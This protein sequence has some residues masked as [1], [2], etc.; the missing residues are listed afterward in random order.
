[1]NTCTKEIFREICGAIHIHTVYSDGSVEYGKLIEVAQNVG[2]DFVI[3]TDHM[4][5]KGKEMGHEGIVDNKFLVLVGYEHNDINDKNHYLVLGTDTVIN[6]QRSA[7][8]YVR[9]VKQAGGIGFIAHPFEKRNYFKKYPS[10]PWTAWDVEG[11]TGIELWN[12]MSEWMEGLKSWKNFFHL[13][14]PRRFLKGPPAGLLRLWDTVNQTRFV[15]GFGGVDAHTFD[16]GFGV[17]RYKIFPIKVELKGIRTH[18]YVASDFWDN[19]FNG[20]KSVVL[21]ALGNGRCFFSNYRRGDARKALFYVMYNDGKIVPP[22]LN[23][24]HAR[25]PANLFVQLPGKGEIHL[26]KNG[27]VAAKTYGDQAEFPLYSKGLYRI[28][29]YRGRYAWIYSNPFPLGDYPLY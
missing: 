7:K 15:S 28:E 10:Y 5:L 17:F 25:F 20:A 16:F 6:E 19:D 23:S 9:L 3:V 21:D 18:L 14:F 4:S 8:K 22:G 1:M 11:Y 27:T 12:H 24:T 2:L 29:V 13:F 26:V